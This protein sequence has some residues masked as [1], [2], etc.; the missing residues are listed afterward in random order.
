MGLLLVKN[1]KNCIWEVVLLGFTNSL[2]ITTVVTGNFVRAIHS[3][4]F[5]KWTL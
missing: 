3:N 4:F 1:A 2:I 5:V